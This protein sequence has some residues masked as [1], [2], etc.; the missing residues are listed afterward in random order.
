MYSGLHSHGYPPQRQAQAENDELAPAD[1]H[2]P[3]L[4]VSQTRPTSVCPISATTLSTSAES[5]CR[6][7]RTINR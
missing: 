2:M 4:M 5:K 1:P 3:E 7:G 6:G